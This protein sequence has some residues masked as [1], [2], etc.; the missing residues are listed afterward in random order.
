MG[1]LATGTRAATA[2]VPLAVFL[3]PAYGKGAGLPWEYSEYQGLPSCAVANSPALAESFSKETRDMNTA[4]HPSA[5]P[6]PRK[7]IPLDQYRPFYTAAQLIEEARQ[8]NKGPSV[9]LGESIVILPDL[10]TAILDHILQE[11]DYRGNKRSK[12]AIACRILA[13]SANH[14]EE[15]LL[16]V[17]Q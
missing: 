9:S 8:F 5:Q 7:V 10:F 12:T 3:S 4:R 1:L 11:F 13:V 17:M 14:Y 2:A 6:D 15:K 16:E